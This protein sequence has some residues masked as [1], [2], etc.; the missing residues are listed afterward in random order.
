VRTLSH[1]LFAFY[2]HFCT[3][4]LTNIFR[5]LY[6]ANRERYFPSMWTENKG[7]LAIFSVSHER[8]VD[9][10]LID[11][12]LVSCTA[13]VTLKLELLTGIHGKGYRLN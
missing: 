4:F 9:C 6:K 3:H 1:Y 7:L 12:G 8:W 10:Y 2:T 11:W 13:L 5:I